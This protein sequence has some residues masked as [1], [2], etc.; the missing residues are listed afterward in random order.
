MESNMI[1]STKDI[2][3]EPLACMSTQ[4]VNSGCN[5]ASVCD[6]CLKCLNNEKISDLH[7]AYREHMQR[8]EMKRLF[9][10]AN[11]FDENYITK[12]SK[13]NQFHTRWMKA[14]CK[15]DKTWC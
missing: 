2:T 3:V 9:P 8:G 12:L 10:A 15:A 13:A 6:L 1:S 11:Y 7:R 14:K 4:C 5:T